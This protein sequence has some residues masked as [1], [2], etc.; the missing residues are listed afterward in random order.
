MRPGMHW[1]NVQAGSFSFRNATTSHILC[2]LLLRFAVLL[3]DLIND[4]FTHVGFLNELVYLF[5]KTLRKN[6]IRVTRVENANDP[7]GS[8]GRG[9]NPHS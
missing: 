3:Y 5:Q 8:V 1:L 4:P 2:C 6:P 7:S 9:Q